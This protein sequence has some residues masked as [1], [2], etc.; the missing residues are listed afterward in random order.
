MQTIEQRRKSDRKRRE[1]WRQ[2]KI[3]QGCKQ[4][5]LMLTPEAQAILAQ[6]KFRTGEPIV[7]IIHRAILELELNLPVN[8]VKNNKTRPIV[9]EMK[10][11][12]NNNSEKTKSR[13]KSTDPKKSGQQDQLKLF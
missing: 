2:K 5:Q 8:P 4:V 12:Q 13:S 11:N 3:A 7:R 9:S 10:K 6:E 1:R